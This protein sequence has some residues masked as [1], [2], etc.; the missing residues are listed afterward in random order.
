MKQKP[1][2]CFSA[3]ENSYGVFAYHTDDGQPLDDEKL[4]ALIKNSAGPAME[5]AEKGIE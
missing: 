3:P 1:K 2:T 5:W 4:K